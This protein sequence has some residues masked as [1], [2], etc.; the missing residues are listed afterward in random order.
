MRWTAAIL[1]LSFAAGAVPAAETGDARRAQVAAATAD[2]LDAL[3]EK[4]LAA[5]VTADV[6]VEE[7]IR[8]TDGHD[9]L[10]L[11]LKRAEQIGGTRWVDDQTCEVKM[12]LRGS[13]LADALVEI[14]ADHPREAGMPPNILRKRVADLSEQTFGASGMSTRAVDR[15]RPD[16]DDEAWRGVP[17]EAVR[18]AVNEARRSAARQILDSV[19]DLPMP[20][21]GDTLGK[22]FNDQQVRDALEGWAMN[23]PVTSVEFQPDL[24]VRV[25]VAVRTGIDGCSRGCKGTQT[26]LIRSPAGA[27]AP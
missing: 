9:E 3:R 21:A 16:R 14:A 22:L 27:A 1:F 26:D 11:T 12:E 5:S 6:T 2:A 10:A 7:F 23:R 8:R 24:E 15:L 25:R 19:A 17:A 18:A 13:E 20:G 4:L